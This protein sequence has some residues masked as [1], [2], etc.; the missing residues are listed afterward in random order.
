METFKQ[1]RTALSITVSE[2][3]KGLN[4]DGDNNTNIK[5]IAQKVK[6]FRAQIMAD[7]KL[8]QTDSYKKMIKQIDTYWE[9][10]FADPITIETSNGQQV[11][12]QPQRTNNILERFFRELK[13]RNRKRSGTI[14]LNKRLKT[15]L[16]DT[17]LIKNLD[18]AEYMEAI[19]DG[20]ATLE[21]RFEKI[22]YNMVLEKLNDEQK[23]YGKI[24][25]EMKKI[26]QRPDLPKKLASL[27]AT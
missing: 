4:D 25:P 9:K 18:K 7:P 1:L 24:S 13:R 16:T 6:R 22:D 17:P 20:N 10:L 8:S 11:H 14:S 3:K 23:T 5:R 12:I 21:E 19:L 27:F 26:I 15:M 2:N